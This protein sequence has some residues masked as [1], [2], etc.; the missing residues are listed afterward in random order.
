MF[1]AF[2]HLNLT[3]FTSLHY[4]CWN[5]S[6]SAPNRSC[7][8]IRRWPVIFCIKKN[9]VKEQMMINFSLI[10]NGALCAIYHGTDC[11]VFN[12]SDKCCKML[13]N[14][15]TSVIII[16]VALLSYNLIV[17]VWFCR[18]WIDI[19]MHVQRYPT[20]CPSFMSWSLALS[21]GIYFDSGLDV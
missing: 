14:N 18:G 12:L 10:E 19:S 21:K 5:F 2:C 11:S 15:N 4:L 17:I 8:V 1:W 7:H 6:F 9:M 3:D 13:P 20:I 16:W